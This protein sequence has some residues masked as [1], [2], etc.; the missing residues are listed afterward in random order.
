L[1]RAAQFPQRIRVI[2][3]RL[4]LVDVQAQL[5]TVL[6]ALIAA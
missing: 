4:P 3:A 5:E 6:C 2:D 1:D